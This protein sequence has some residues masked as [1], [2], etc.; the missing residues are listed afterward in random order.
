MDSRYYARSEISK[1]TTKTHF[2]GSHCMI[3]P[4]TEVRRVSTE[5]GYGLFATTLIPR[6]TITWVL[7]ALDIRM[8]DAQV[9]AL[10]EAYQPVIE[11]Y[12]YRDATGRHILCWDFGRFMNHSC[13]PTTTSI[14]TLCDVALRDIQP[15][16]QLTC[17]YAMLNLTESVTCHCGSKTCRGTIAANDLIRLAPATDK[18]AAG[19]VSQI[20]ETPQPLLPFMNEGERE[21]LLK[22]AR[23]E[24]PVPSCLDNRP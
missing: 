23:G 4:S 24:L 12:A 1:L 15:G 16:E 3:H 6:G 13:E 7:D 21:R 9:A 2:K 11:R 14:G 10:P 17:E 19:L 18:L 8:T 5:V 22:I 20:A